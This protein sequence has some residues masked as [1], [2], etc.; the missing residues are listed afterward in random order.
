MTD[1]WLQVLA[2][3]PWALP[4]MAALVVGDAFLVVIPG[5]AA[6]TTFGALAVAEGAPPLFAVIAVAAVAALTGDVGCYFLGRTVG[7][8]RWRWMRGRRVSAAFGWARDAL[9]RRGATLMFTARFIPFAR[10]AVNIAAGASGMRL[11]RYVVL[12]APAATA[13]ALYQALLGAAVAAIIPGGTVAA[14]VV[15][16]ALALAI[17]AVA[18]ALVARARRRRAPDV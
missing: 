10:L 8:D 18:D 13:W 1:D 16:I 15:S 2:H 3:S 12:A 4:A 17:G 6:V 9:A 7:L 5:E 14:V 11:G